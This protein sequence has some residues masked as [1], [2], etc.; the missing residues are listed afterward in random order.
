MSAALPADA[1]AVAVPG[2]L[3]TRLGDDVVI[4]G[5][6][7]SVYYGLSGSGARLWE[8]LQSPRRLTELVETL[9]AEYEVD[10]GVA[11]Q[12]VNQLLTDLQARG[13][14]AIT[15]ADRP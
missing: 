4:L 15:T 2:Q 9:V 5:L 13:L 1:L 6:R 7:D 10:R 8:L 11:A 14:V 12:D 3:S